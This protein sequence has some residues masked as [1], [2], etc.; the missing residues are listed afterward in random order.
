MSDLTQRQ[1]PSTNLGH[2]SG[3]IADVLLNHVRTFLVV[4]AQSILCH[5]T[6]TRVTSFADLAKMYTVHRLHIMM[7]FQAKGWNTEE[8]VPLMKKH[9]SY[10]PAC[11]NRD[12]H[13][14]DGPIKVSYGTY[15]Y[16]IMQDF[17]RGVEWQGF[18]S[19][20]TCRI[21]NRASQ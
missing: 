8:L 11:N 4:A 9:E 2:L 18:T 15:T 3:L 16:P 13:G 5:V 10:Q 14:F 19:L 17:L 21:S 7:N 12:I 1:R 6:T 20:M